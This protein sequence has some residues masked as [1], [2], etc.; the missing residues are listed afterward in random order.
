MVSDFATGS[1]QRSYLVV[2]TWCSSSTKLLF[3]YT[4]AFGM[5]IMN[6]ALP[7]FHPREPIFGCQ[8]LLP[9]DSETKLLKKN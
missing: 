5:G 9:I 6:V 1:L 2:P 7:L 8:K 3:L 4:D